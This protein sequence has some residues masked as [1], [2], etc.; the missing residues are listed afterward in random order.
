MKIDLALPPGR[1][2]LI[3]VDLQ[4]EQRSDPN[5]S[6]ADFDRVLT[7]SRGLLAAARAARV[8]VVHTA[9]RRDFSVVP[10]L[11]FEPMTG[12]G[13]PA[14]SDPDGPGVSICSEVE[15]APGEAI[16]FKNGAS[17]FGSGE[18]DGLLRSMETEW[19]IVAGVWTEAC[20]ALSVRDAIELGY[21]VLLVKDACG[22]GTDTMHR[23]GVLNIANRL[24]GGAVCDCE[25]AMKL[26]SGGTVS[27]WANTKP[28]PI[29]F[30]ADTIDAL[31]DA[32]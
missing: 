21:R 27:V 13:R 16:V 14:F 17:A 7:A 15:P 19:V 29:L 5:I 30:E 24:Y 8:P 6:A 2:A 10:P 25:R 32:L 3:L 26:L 20:V 9:Y 23:S 4:E 11:P 31:Y 18:L 28:V 22:S 12:D 1:S